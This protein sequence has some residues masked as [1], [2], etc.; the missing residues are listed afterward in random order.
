[1]RRRYV[2]IDGELVEVTEDYRNIRPANASHNIIPEITPYKSMVTG[3]MVQGRRQHREHLKQ[4]NVV[5][6]GDQTHTMKA[7]GP[8]PLPGL[9]ERLIEVTNAVLD[10]RR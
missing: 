8:R 7:F 2:Q 6:V 1:M 3:E 4:H 10:R 9:K 5:E